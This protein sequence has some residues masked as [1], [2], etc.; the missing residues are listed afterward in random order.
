MVQ[1][2]FIEDM[3]VYVKFVSGMVLSIIRDNFDD[4]LQFEYDNIEGM[5][6][7]FEFF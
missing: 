1:V 5:I 7:F 2:Q 3:G 4:L 6:F